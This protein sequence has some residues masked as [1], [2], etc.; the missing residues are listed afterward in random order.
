MLGGEE[1]PAARARLIK[2]QIGELQSEGCDDFLSAASR[3]AL[4]MPLI[5]PARDG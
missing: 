2:K 5:L 1:I 3:E 4:N